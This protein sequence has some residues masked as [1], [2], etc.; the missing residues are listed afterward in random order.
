MCLSEEWSNRNKVGMRMEDRVM[1]LEATRL[2]RHPQVF[3]TPG[4]RDI[5]GFFF[6]RY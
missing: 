2:G 1:V 3:P 5:F 6:V 4:Q